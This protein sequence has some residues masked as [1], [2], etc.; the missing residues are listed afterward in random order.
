MRYGH[1]ILKHGSDILINTKTIRENG[2][3]GNLVIIS[4]ELTGPFLFSAIF[5]SWEV[6]LTVVWSIDCKEDIYS[7]YIAHTNHKK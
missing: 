1:L 2:Y 5:G 3:F 6:D 7:I 4:L